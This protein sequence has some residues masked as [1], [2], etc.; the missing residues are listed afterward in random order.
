MADARCRATRR[1]IKTTVRV[2]RL[3]GSARRPFFNTENK[4][5]FLLF[6]AFFYRQQENCPIALVFVPQG[7]DGSHEQDSG[8][9]SPTRNPALPRIFRAI[10][11]IRST[12]KVKKTASQIVGSS[13][14]SSSYSQL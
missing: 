7:G 11:F 8:T 14:Q 6:C 4:K 5:R 1:N 13:K 9:G 10:G 12:N 3:L 2:N